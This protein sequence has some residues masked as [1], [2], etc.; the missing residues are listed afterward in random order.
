MVPS[1]KTKSKRHKKRKSRTE[2]KVI[3][4]TR[5]SLLISRRLTPPVTSSGS[6]SEAAGP[7]REVQNYSKVPV[8]VKV[9]DRN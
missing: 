4:E 1:A 8:D 7:Q 3:H 9:D 6:D 2:G 5:V